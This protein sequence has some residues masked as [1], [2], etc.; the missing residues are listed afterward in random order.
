M[1]SIDLSDSGYASRKLHISYV[2]MLLVTIGYIATGKWPA[3]SETYSQ[4]IMG[5][6]SGAGL[7]LGSNTLT[8]WVHLN[9]ASK[10]K[11]TVAK[12]EAIPPKV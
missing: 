2:V 10:D 12:T 6:L 8:K 9:A 4:Y 11:A 7:Y 1:D 5:L 3:L